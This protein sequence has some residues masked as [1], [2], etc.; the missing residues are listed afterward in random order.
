[1]VLKTILATATLP[2]HPDKERLTQKKIRTWGESNSSKI[3]VD[4]IQRNYRRGWKKKQLEDISQDVNFYH[5]ET[6]NIREMARFHACVLW[7]FQ[8]VHLEKLR[9][10]RCQW[11]SELSCGAR[12][13]L[14][15]QMTTKMM[16]WWLQCLWKVWQT[17]VPELV[18]LLQICFLLPTESLQNNVR[19]EGQVSEIVPR[20]PNLDQG[21]NNSLAKGTSMNHHVLKNFHAPSKYTKKST[22]VRQM[23]LKNCRNGMRGKHVLECFPGLQFL[24]RIVKWNIQTW[25]DWGPTVFGIHRNAVHRAWWH[26]RQICG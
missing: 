7:T 21:C 26:L 13:G 2:P 16:W 6:L 18:L 14:I 10:L 1:M 8:S 15:L 22:P 20:L 23:G 19:K 12:N 25:Q 5:G 4:F 9:V 17:Q 24:A 11:S 3:L